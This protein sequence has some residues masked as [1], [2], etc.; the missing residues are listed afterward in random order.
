MD[1]GTL[2][3]VEA[4]MP[5]VLPIFQ[6]LQIMLQQFLVVLVADVPVE[7]AVI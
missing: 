5:S 1:G 3:E 6:V 4:H 7:E 2:A